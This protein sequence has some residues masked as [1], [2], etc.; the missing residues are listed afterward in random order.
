M[1]IAKE[2]RGLFQDIAKH[3]KMVFFYFIRFN[4]LLKFR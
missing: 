2:N 3:I 1:F 4:S